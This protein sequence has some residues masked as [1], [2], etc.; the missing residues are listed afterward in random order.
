MKFG[1]PSA[2]LACTLPLALVAGCSLFN[3]PPPPTPPAP[4]RR[5]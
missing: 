5:R 3:P 1:P 2:A 4:R